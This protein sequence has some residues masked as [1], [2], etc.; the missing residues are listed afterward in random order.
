MALVR[1]SCGGSEVRFIF[2]ARFKRTSE[3]EPHENHRLAGV[4]L[5]P[6][7]ASEQAASLCELRNRDTRWYASMF[8]FCSRGVKRS[9]CL[10]LSLA[11]RTSV[12]SDRRSSSQK[13]H[14]KSSSGRM[15]NKLKI[16]LHV[17]LGNCRDCLGRD[18][19]RGVRMD[20]S[21]AGRRH[22]P[23]LRWTLRRGDGWVCTRA[24]SSIPALANF[25]FHAKTRRRDG[26]A[27][28][29]KHDRL[30]GDWCGPQRVVCLVRLLRIVGLVH[31]G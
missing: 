30:L 2:S 9:L 29:Y 12:L 28:N 11:A 13:L 10:F 15:I 26:M 17:N 7:F 8:S 31:D 19:R 22:C 5:I 1:C 27:E 3:P 20:A 6:K 24:S 21:R 23:R 16:V 25:Y 14:L 4:P 18:N